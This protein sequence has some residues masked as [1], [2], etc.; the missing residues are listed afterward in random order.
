MPPLSSQLPLWAVADSDDVLRP[1]R[2]E[3]VP[4]R[5][6]DLS[7]SAIL[8]ALPDCPN[9]REG[10]WR[11]NQR[12]C[13]KAHRRENWEL[14]NRLRVKRGPAFHTPRHVLP[15]EEQGA[16]ERQAQSQDARVL[17]WMRAHPGRHIPPDVHAGLEAENVW[18]LEKSV[19]RA[20][21][22]LTARGELVH[23]TTDRRPGPFGMN[24]TWEKG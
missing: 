2:G 8:C 6:Q 13:C 9:P 24:S 3:T 5:R 21:T 14:E 17:A 19:R 23:H 18:I 10:S 15:F 20:L 11:W 1:G 16:G 4:S 12:F 7:E 22:N